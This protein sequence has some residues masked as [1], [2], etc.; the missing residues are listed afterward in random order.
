MDG[1]VGVELGEAVDMADV[2]VVVVEVLAVTPL[3][4]VSSAYVYDTVVIA[5]AKTIPPFN[6]ISGIQ[7]TKTV[8]I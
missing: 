6:S 7:E 1:L 3:S 4:V 2:D 8:A 5:S